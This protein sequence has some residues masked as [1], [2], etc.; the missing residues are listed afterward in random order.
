VHH[1]VLPLAYILAAVAPDV[2]PLAMHLIIVKLALKVAAVPPFEVPLPMLLSVNILSLVGGAVDPILFA[3][4]VVLVVE[5]VAFIGGAVC[6]EIGTLAI[7][8]VI[9]PVAHIH[10]SISVDDPPKSLLPII[11]KIAVVACAIRPDLR[12]TTMPDRPR[13]LS[14]VLNFI[15]NDFFAFFDT[16]EAL[17]FELILT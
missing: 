8:L 17:S 16:F 4:A 14:D 15:M 5:P 11:D 3:F 2:G 6:M 1:V 13:P 12:A 9:L 10:V 7:G